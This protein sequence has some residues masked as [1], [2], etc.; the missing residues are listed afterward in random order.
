[1]SALHPALPRHV[2]L[3]GYGGLLPFVGLAILVA[4]DAN[5][6]ALW[7]GA[8]IGYG[9][10]ILSF[11]GALHWGFAMTVSNLDAAIRR[12]AF[13]W[14]VIPALLA[15]PAAVLGNSSA[16]LILGLGFVLHLVQDMKLAGPA[17]LPAWYLPL[18]W[19]LTLV[20]G[21]CILAGAWYAAA[22]G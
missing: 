18:R 2:A 5:H 21:I 8:L 1:M 9:A 6:A 16:A 13:V 11:V 4:I 15:W 7:Y 20:A 14:S 12:R 22:R 19:R 10:V 3:L 17:G